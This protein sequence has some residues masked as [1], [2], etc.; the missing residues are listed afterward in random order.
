MTRHESSAAVERPDSVNVGP[1]K[2]TLGPWSI[3][4]AELPVD[5][6]FDWAILASFDGRQYCIAEAFGRVAP[7]IWPNAEANAHLIAAAPQMLA[8]LQQIER[9]LTEH[10]KDRMDAPEFERCDWDFGEEC[11]GSLD[12]VRE[13]IAKA[14]GAA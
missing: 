10:S 12:V 7:V 2:H 4:R 6:E 1:N 5:G 8:A 11:G 14:T 3:K 9:A 13:A